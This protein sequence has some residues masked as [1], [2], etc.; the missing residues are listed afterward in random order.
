MTEAVEDR[1]RNR[2]GSALIGA[3]FDNRKRCER[4]AMW[5]FSNERRRAVKFT[6]HAA[7]M[8]TVVLLARW[9]YVSEEIP[10]VGWERVQGRQVT[11]G[12]AVCEINWAADEGPVLGGI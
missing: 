9:T 1:K 3:A 8:I 7:W 4:P 2:I 10:R 12:L 6:A 11:V 5:S